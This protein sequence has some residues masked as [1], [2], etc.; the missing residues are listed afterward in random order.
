MKEVTIKMSEKDL[1]EA[2][3]ILN[4]FGKT[5]MSEEEKAERI[6]ESERIAPYKSYNGYSVDITPEVI[7]AAGLKDKHLKIYGNDD[8][9]VLY[10]TDLDIEDIDWDGKEVEEWCE[11]VVFNYFGEI[12]IE[13]K[14]FWGDLYNPFGGNVLTVDYT[15]HI[16]SVTLEPDDEEEENNQ[17]ES[18]SPFS[19]F[20]G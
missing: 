20:W 15:D 16:I 19:N 11:G 4:A 12:E 1:K 17:E 9:N 13:A 7:E 14:N 3:K 5:I 18:Y 2:N 6:E 10:I 8:D